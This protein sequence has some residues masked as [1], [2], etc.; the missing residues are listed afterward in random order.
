MFVLISRTRLTA[1]NKHR[2]IW[3]GQDILPGD[4]Y[5]REKS[6]FNDRPQDACWHPEC[7]TKF[8]MDNLG[9]PPKAFTPYTHERPED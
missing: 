7:S 9:K 6:T 3:C 1:L 4:G 8:M 2:C 5:I